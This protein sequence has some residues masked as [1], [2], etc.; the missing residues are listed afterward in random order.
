MK[1]ILALL[2]AGLI[3]AACESGPKIRANTAPGANLAGYKTYTFAAKQGT[4]RG[5]NVETPLTGY[6]KEATRREMDARGYRYVEGADADLMIAFGANAQEKVDVRSTPSPTYGYGYYGY[7]AGVYGGWGYGG[8]TEVDTV[9]YKVG[10][11]NID[12]VDYA[13]KQLVWEG[14]AEGK[15]TDKAMADPRGAVNLVVTEIFKQFPGN[16][17]GAAPATGTSS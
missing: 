11:A 17:G 12:V 10:T 15:L 16:A 2:A 13:K 5:G 3:L 7:R 1:K 4:D 14:I 8:G 6:F 9:R